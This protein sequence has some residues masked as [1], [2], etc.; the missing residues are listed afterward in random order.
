MVAPTPLAALAPSE[1][2]EALADRRHNWRWPMLQLQPF[3]QP[4]RVQRFLQIPLGAPTPSGVERASDLAGQRPHRWRCTPQPSPR[5]RRVRDSLGMPLAALT[6]SEGEGAAGLAD[7]RPH[8]QRLM[9]QP[10]PQ[11]R[12]VRDSLGMPLAAPTPSEGEGAAG[13][14]DRR[15]HR[16]RRTP[17]PSPQPR[18]V[19]DSLLIRL[20]APTP[21]EGEGATLGCR[22]LRRQRRSSLLR[23]PLRQRQVRASGRTHLGRRIRSAQI[24]LVPKLRIR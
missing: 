13:L 21:S 1:E 11:P 17:Q 5:P 15:P 18:R 6:P 12:R 7:R 23:I 20:A 22:K 2:V 16:Q 24:R 10:S 14:A 4:R 8:R 3:L 19:L 9:P